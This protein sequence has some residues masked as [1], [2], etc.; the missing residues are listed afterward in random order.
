MYCFDIFMVTYSQHLKNILTHIVDS[1]TILVDNHSLEQMNGLKKKL[2][3]QVVQVKQQQLS[4]IL[5]V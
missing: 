4:T 2:K 3:K 1:Y 5:V